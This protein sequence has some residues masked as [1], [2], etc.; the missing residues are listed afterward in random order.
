VVG[1]VVVV[2]VRHQPL[3]D[4]EDT[5]GLENAEDLAVNALKRWCV[6][7]GFDGVDGIE[8]VVR[9]RHLLPSISE[10]YLGCGERT[11]HEVTL[12]VLELVR[13]TLLLGVGSGTLNLVVVVVQSNNVNTSE[14]DDLTGGSTDTA[15]NIQD[16]HVVLEVHFVGK[17]VLVAGNGLVERL[18]ICVAGKVERLSPAV[19][20]QVGREVVV[21]S[22]EGSVF[23]S[24]FLGLLVNTVYNNATYAYLACLLGLIARGLVVPMLEVLVYSGLLGSLVFL[25][26]GSHATA[27]L[28]RLAVHGL[29]ELGIASMVFLF[30]CNGSHDGY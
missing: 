5:T 28:C 29:V 24:S 3:V 2:L 27:S 6:N 16:A 21:M 15:A 23:V 13:Q 25:Q 26:H 11:Y 8:R 12:D 18:A 9:E 1:V 7:S 17:V 20:V 4:T 10:E 19:L 22:C 30:E 14:L